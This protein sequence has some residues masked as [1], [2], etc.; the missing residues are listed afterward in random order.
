MSTR[1][2]KLTDDAVANELANLDGWALE[3][4]Q[5]AKQYTF[6][7]YKDGVVFAVAVAQ[8]ADREDHHP[9]LYIGYAKV[10]VA[11]NTHDV[12]GISSLD[13]KLAHLIEGI[14]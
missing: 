7:T 8:Y 14:I 2:Q 12:D 6:K 1:P 10:R 9:D 13:F 5:I 11:L 3:N 4:G